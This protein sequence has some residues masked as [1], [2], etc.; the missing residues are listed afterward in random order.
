MK[1]L[2]NYNNFLNEAYEVQGEF[3]QLLNN[4]RN[5]RLVPD[6]LYYIKDLVNPND[7]KVL[8]DFINAKIAFIINPKLH[9]EPQACI[10]PDE[11]KYLVEPDLKLYYYPEITIENCPIGVIEIEEINFTKTYARDFRVEK[12]TTAFIH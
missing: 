2:I 9:F 7:F 3:E 12:G 1:H 10:S 5:I 8:K 4:M 11:Y 6:K